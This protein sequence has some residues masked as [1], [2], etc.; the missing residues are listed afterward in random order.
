MTGRRLVVAV[1]AAAAA[2]A[3][4]PVLLPAFVALVMAALVAPVAGWLRRLGLARGAAA[5][6]GVTLALAA[7]LMAGWGCYHAIAG[8][9]RQAPQYSEKIRA[10]ARSV[11]AKL[12]ALQRHTTDLSP[13]GGQKDQTQRNGQQPARDWTSIL[14]RGLGSFFEAAGLA[15]F[16]PFLALFLLIEQPRLEAAFDRAA[17]RDYDAARLREEGARV[18]RAY[19]FGN[20]ALGAAMSVLQ[21][22]LFAA[23]GLDNAAGLGLVTGF[24]NVIPVLGLPLALL[25]PLAQGLGSFHGVWPFAL[26]GGSLLAIHLTAANWVIPKTI[27]SRVK[28]NA[29]AGTLGMLFFGW[30]WGIVGFLLAVPLTALVKVG[31]ECSAGT[32]PLGGLLADAEER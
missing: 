25:L 9:V 24:L 19:I 5:S 18:I 16:V 27:G 15:V 30:L 21:W 28:V 14:L 7:T 26:V 8:V 13:E 17:G 2:Y 23:V 11:D 12:R 6:I 20:L 22:A 1:V 10:A 32:A 29:T 4:T 3:A 31:L